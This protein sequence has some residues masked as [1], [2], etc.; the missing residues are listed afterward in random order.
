M[1]INTFKGL[2]TLVFL[3]AFLAI[4][5]YAYRGRNKAR[6]DAQAQ[7]IIDDKEG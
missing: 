7:A 1:D 4:V 5:F 3:F 6:F 2:M